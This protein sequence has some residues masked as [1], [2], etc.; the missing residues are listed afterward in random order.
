MA[1]YGEQ[2]AIEKLF[3][4]K[5]LSCTYAYHKLLIFCYFFCKCA[6]SSGYMCPFK[7]Y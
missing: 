3:E 1:I 7:L 5:L 4:N 2:F 6:E